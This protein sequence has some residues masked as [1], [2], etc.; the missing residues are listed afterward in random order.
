MVG[1]WRKKLVGVRGDWS[2]F[3]LCLTPEHWF[4]TLYCILLSIAFSIFRWKQ[5]SFTI[6][7]IGLLLYLE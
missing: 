2:L 4:L 1:V 7:F 3:V 5:N 6:I